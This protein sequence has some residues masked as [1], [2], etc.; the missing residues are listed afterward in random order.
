[1]PAASS[2]QFLFLSF[3][4]FYLLIH[5]PRATSL[6]FS[7]NFSSS[8]DPCDAELR[9][10]RDAHMG[11]GMLELTKNEIRGDPFSVGRASYARPVPL[12]DNTTGELASF[13]SN[14]TFQIKPKDETFYHRCNGSG[15]G[16]AFFL[17]HYPSMIPPNSYGWN[18]ALFNDSN[19]LNATGDDRVVAVEFDTFYNSQWDHSQNH[20]GIDVNSINSK[21]YKNVTKGLVSEDAI[22]T[23]MISYNNL[24]GILAVYLQIDDSEPYN[25]TLPV[26]MKGNLPE[27]VAVGFSAATGDC[28]EL[29]QVLSWSF[30]STLESKAT[31]G[32][33]RRLVPVLVPAAVA[34]LVLLCTAVGCLVRRRRIWKKLNGM[35]DG[36]SD[37]E[38][39]HAEFERGVGPRR[40]G[41]RELAAATSNFAEEEKLGRG[42]FGN[43]YRGSLG[44][45]DCLVAVKMFSAE[46]S[47]QGR[48]AFEAEV[49]I[50]SRLRHRNLVQLLG[51]C[52]SRRGLL[53]VYELVPE[54][55]LDRHLYGSLLSWSQ[56]YNIILGLGSAL[57][58]LHTEWDQCVLH[59]DIKPSNILLGPS[60][61]T[62][63]GDFGLARLVDHGA[64]SRT[65]Q[66]VMGTAG[67][68]DPEFI[69][70]RRP[71]TESD[72]YSF[73]VVLLE[74][75]TGR[76]PEMEHPDRVIPLLKWIW[77]LY[78]RNTLL[79]AVDERLAEGK[80]DDAGCS[81]EW[82]LRRVLVV[83][84]WCAHP[85]PGVRPSIVQAMNVLQ[86]EDVTLP[87][88]SRQVYNRTTSDF[89][90]GSRGY[91][92]PAAENICR[93]DESWALS[94]GR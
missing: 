54:G 52:D 28:I 61:S 77:D 45:Q 36:D 50:I 62:K 64:G 8:G 40:Y 41:Y 17:A 30:N 90:H 29:H 24:T 70:S 91:D 10:E 63:L 72:V 59:G 75:I 7:F 60:H 94:G 86:S 5:A 1:M 66:V 27:Q 79:E 19:S 33:R 15:D 12:W 31:T 78:D 73:G 25:I 47:V 83:G 9:C 57:R 37:G 76:R 6:S 68:I 69:R 38:R 85:D 88:L 13:T 84:L 20:V 32:G 42:G 44:D 14:F 16:M 80:L 4:L 93:D 81:C 48:K 55:S 22:M 82:Q 87:V 67:Y 71:S 53:L 58:Y 21:A 2:R 65:T 23:G 56:R 74:I 11:P 39:E 26:D 18:L 89:S 92:S 46:S 35:T 51:W 43:V 49:K 34:F 3:S